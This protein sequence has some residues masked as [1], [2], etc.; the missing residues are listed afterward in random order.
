MTG[1]GRQGKR[2]H[3]HEHDTQTQGTAIHLFRSSP[4]SAAHLGVWLHQNANK[5]DDPLIHSKPEE[6]QQ[7]IF[8]L[9]RQKSLIGKQENKLWAEVVYDYCDTEIERFI[10]AVSVGGVNFC[11]TFILELNLGE[12]RDGI[13]TFSW[14]QTVLT[15]DLR[16]RTAFDCDT[17]IQLRKSMNMN[18][19]WTEWSNSIQKIRHAP[20]PFFPS[21]VCVLAVIK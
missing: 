2:K 9:K 7:Q 4:L 3:T 14:L 6:Q 16:V 5:E 20:E 12:F 17:V 8:G 21:D 13:C 18:H 1:A 15:A 19:N 11:W 10:T